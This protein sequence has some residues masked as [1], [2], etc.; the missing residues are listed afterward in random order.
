MSGLN[1]R[2]GLVHRHVPLF[3]PLCVAACCLL[4]AGAASASD[5]TEDGTLM[6]VRQWDPGTGELVG[7]LPIH[8]AAIRL[9][10][11]D[12][13]KP[14]FDLNEPVTI[15]WLPK[16]KLVHHDSGE[17]GI[18][19]EPRVFAGERWL[20]A[21]RDGNVVRIAKRLFLIRSIILGESKWRQATPGSL[22]VGEK[23]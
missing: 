22:L 21:K 19:P 4:I 18:S 13:Q 17:V 20:P 8:R 23:K 5:S 16:P 6:L 14:A 2:Q 7:W 1:T 3:M 11:L 15:E 10:I 9:V 12:D